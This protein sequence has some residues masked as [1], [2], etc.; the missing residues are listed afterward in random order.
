MC[1]GGKC[2]SQ[3]GIESKT[4][5]AVGHIQRP[6]SNLSLSLFSPPHA[7]TQM[8]H[9]VGFAVSRQPIVMCLSVTGLGLL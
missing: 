8:S 1:T 3:T 6:A 4:G 7:H 5:C 2:L 9:L